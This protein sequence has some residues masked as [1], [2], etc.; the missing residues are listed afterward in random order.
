[1]QDNP[2]LEKVAMMSLGSILG[3]LYCLLLA[4]SKIFPEESKRRQNGK[5][6]NKMD[7]SKVSVNHWSV[8]LDTEGVFGHLEYVVGIIAWL[9]SEGRAL[10]TSKSPLSYEQWDRLRSKTAELVDDL[11]GTKSVAKL[12]ELI[13]ERGV[14]DLMT[15]VSGG[16]EKETV[17]QWV[18]TLKYLLES[19][20][21]PPE[22]KRRIIDNLV[23]AAQ[24]LQ[25]DY[26]LERLA[27][28]RTQ[29]DLVLRGLYVAQHKNW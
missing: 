29:G 12:Y 18:I 25:E 20:V 13:A 28:D 16:G 26:I 22:P 1:M 23:P 8:N 24:Y 17:R 5:E 2:M 27:N 11:H 4:D 15:L 6:V 3:I 10:L 21:I 14:S 7:F 19:G 9:N